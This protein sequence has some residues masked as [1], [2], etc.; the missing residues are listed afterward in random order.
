[1][2][3]WR[4]LLWFAGFIVAAMVAVSIWSDWMAERTIK[5]FQA[6]ARARGDWLTLVNSRGER[7]IVEIKRSKP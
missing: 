6:A 2:S 5:R 7:E 3:E 1:M 4:L